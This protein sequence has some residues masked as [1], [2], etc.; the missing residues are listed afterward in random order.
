MSTSPAAAAG[1]TE[2]AVDSAAPAAP[3]DDPTAVDA[4]TDAAPGADERI[5][6]LE[7]RWQREREA[8]LEAEQIAE[9]GLRRLWEAKND[10]DRRVE[11]RTAEL[12]RAQALTE[13]SARAKTEFLAELA[14]RVRTPLQTI[15]SALELASPATPTD[16]Q[17]L[18]DASGAAVEL[19]QL[20]TN[21]LELTQLETGTLRAH[22]RPVQLRD[23]LDEIGVRWRET[24]TSRGL[25]LVPEAAGDAVIDDARLHQIAD[26]LLDNVAR[27]SR[28]GVVRLHLT[29]ERAEVSGMRSSDRTT[30][31][32]VVLTVSDDGPGLDASQLDRAFEPF[33]TFDSTASGSGIGLALVRELCGQLGGTVTATGEPGVTI[34]VRIPGDAPDRPPVDSH[35]GPPT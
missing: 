28:P 34:V 19:R 24:L 20:F 22:P 11:E 18:G 35:E 6:V 17:R 23:V 2:D 13:A 31:S 16:R 33:V 15:L 26:A 9:T 21:L 25:L 1:W 30:T 7:R 3:A 27:Y 32:E 4:A 14:H 12:V 5:R 10:L 29:V 8:R